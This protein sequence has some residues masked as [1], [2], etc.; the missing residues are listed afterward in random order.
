MN[1]VNVY[2]QC[3]HN[4]VWNLDIFTHDSVGDGFIFG[5]RMRNTKAQIINFDNKIK[6]ISFFD[7]QF[8]QPRSEL[9]KFTDYDFFP[10]SVCYDEYST[11]DFSEVSHVCAEKCIDFQLDQNFRFITIPTITYNDI[12]KSYLES[13]NELYIE[14]FLVAANKREL[15]E[16]KIILT[17]VVK[18]SQLLDTEYMDELLNLITSYVEITGI[19]LVPSFRFSGK[20]YKDIGVINNLLKFIHMLKLNDMYV[21]LAYCDIE[22]LLYSVAGIDSVSIGTY[23]NTRRFDLNNFDKPDGKPKTQPNRRIYS[24]KMLQWID[25]N[26]IEA[27]KEY[28]SFSNLFELNRY[29]SLSVPKV[30][31]WHFTFPELYK[32]FMM[33]IFNQYKSLPNS[34]N[35]R[36]E[37]L[38][39]L[40]EDAINY[41][42]EIADSRILFDSN[43]D[44]SHLSAWLTALNKFDKFIRIR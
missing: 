20:R 10:N 34:Y 21:H 39:I 33:S 44:G 30:K 4:E 19:Y 31:D 43:S 27:L 18:D 9:D 12:P 14:P 3:G 1:S 11:K 29:I 7:P 2:H 22:G 16:K 15:N 23:E 42:K 25:F 13:L 37:M 35:E 38:S 41:N 24:N 8:Y 5:P 36:F 28:D 40:F 32:H 17:V 26:Y 6:E